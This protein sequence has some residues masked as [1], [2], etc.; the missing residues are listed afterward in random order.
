MYNNNT[1]NT[2][3]EISDAFNDYFFNIAPEL[4]NK[5]PSTHTSHNSYLR[6]D[7]PN[8]MVMPIIVNSDTVNAITSLK[9]KKGH[10]NE[11]AVSLIK[12]N[13]EILAKPLTMLFNQSINTG[14]FP[15]RFK[16]GKLIPIYKTGNKTDLSNYRP[17]TILPIF[18]KVFE[19]LMKKHLLIF[20]NKMKILNNKQFGFRPGLSTFDALLTQHL[21][22]INL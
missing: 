11:I 20:L 5:L 13:K 22:K 10:I 3:L 9:N 1:M 8:S 21:M 2:P 12:E 15:D 18:S 6:G 17:I 19:A 7:Y 4:A 14:I 16:L